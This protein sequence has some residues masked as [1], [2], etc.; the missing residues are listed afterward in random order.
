M[1]KIFQ[2]RNYFKEDFK[3]ERATL[4]PDRS[5]GAWSPPFFTVGTY[6]FNNGVNNPLKEILRHIQYCINR[7]Y[8]QKHLI[9]TKFPNTDNAI[10]TRKSFQSA[11]RGQ[12]STLLVVY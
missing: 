12:L 8:W 11:F 10:Q 3:E 7:L 6:A 2:K 1:W 4:R 5:N 9:Y